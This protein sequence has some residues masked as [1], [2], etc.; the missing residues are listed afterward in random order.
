MHEQLGRRE[1]LGVSAEATLGLTAA[2]L[3]IPL[4]A[5]QEPA[6]VRVGII[7]TGNRGKSLL[8]NLLHMKGVAVPA[9]CDIKQEAVEG[10]TKML[11]DAG[12]PAPEAYTRDEHV[13]QDLLKR[14]DLDAV[15]I[16]TPWNWH[17][18][19][20]LDSMRAGKYTGVEVPAAIS[21]DECWA[22]V[23]THEETG[24]HCMMLENWS[25]R[26]DNLAILNM[27]RAGLLGEI[28]HAHCSYS[29]DCVGSYFFDGEG[30]P[31][32]P[33]E[34]LIDNNRCQYPTHAQGPVLSWM[35]INCGDRYATMTAMAT[36]S[37]GINSYFARTKGP[38]HPTAKRPFKQGDVV[39]CLVK[40]QKGKTVVI[41][42][43]MMLPR[44]YDNRWS[45][46]GTM[47]IYNEQRNSVYIEGRSSQS[48]QWELF[49]PYQTEFDHPWWTELEP[50]AAQAGHG[51]TDFV[52][53][54]MFIKAV[55]EKAPT[56]V[57]IYD[58]ATMSSIIPLSEASIAQGGMPVDCP[59]FTR[60]KWESTKPKFAV[61]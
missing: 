55:R 10:A 32:W 26:R 31:R 36:A 11:T 17:A 30:N 61:V 37:K 23:N 2:A 24:V 5:A 35:D 46:Q 22:L 34:F 18:P 29:H 8:G 58:S 20:A 7:G 13:Y 49:D 12:Q 25:F 44:P 40:S 59:D 51:G 15:L 45:V 21:L 4:A 48:H 56:P 3:A 52:E 47:G 54:K 33:G 16:A 60:G 53:L 57:D 6:P 39:T 9:I 38:D 19:M 1:F 41:N 28:M 42:C 43:D 50:E 27:I 14:D